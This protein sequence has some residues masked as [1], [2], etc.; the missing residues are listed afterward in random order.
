MALLPYAQ[1]VCFLYYLEM[2]M[3]AFSNVRKTFA[4]HPYGMLFVCLIPAVLLTS[5]I[6]PAV[7]AVVAPLLLPMGATAFVVLK[8]REP[9][10]E[11]GRCMSVIKSV[12][13][14]CGQAVIGALQDAQAKRLRAAQRKSASKVVYAA[15]AVVLLLSLLFYAGASRATG[16]IAGATEFT[17]IANNVELG[18]QYV[19][20]VQ[21][22]LTQINQ[23]KTMLQNLQ[24]MAPSGMLDS[25]AQQLWQDQGMSQAFM[26]LRTMYVNGQRLAYSSSNIDTQFRTAHPGFGNYAG[27]DYNATYRNWSQG[28]LDAIKNAMQVLGVQSDKFNTEQGMIQEL[29][30]RSSSASGQMEALKVGHDVGVQQV[31]QLQQ[32]RQLQMAQMQAQNAYMA[33][34]QSKQDAGREALQDS[35]TTGVKKVRTLK[36]IQAQRINQTTTN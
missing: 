1:E 17:Q 5:V 26:N 29:Q 8:W 28:S 20:Q 9:S 13:E 18:L 36:E 25:S 14:P 3:E 2:I 6:W 21:Q 4:E 31:S 10:D 19:E 24:K 7:M 33:G 12:L 11:Q 15:V 34:Q 23:Y 32:L 30:A 27:M 16:M 35:L 22:T